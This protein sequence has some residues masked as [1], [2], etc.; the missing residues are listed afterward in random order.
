M[1]AEALII[2]RSG[3]LA[4]SLAQTL[5][6]GAAPWR[7]R[8]LDRSALDLTRPEQAG[9][10][11]TAA[12]PELV[13]IAA[14]YTAVDK[15]ESDEDTARL[16]NAASP[17]AIA[18]AC[19]RVG[20]ALVHVSTDYVFDGT[21]PAPYVETDPLAP[22]NA[23][24]RT[25]AEG[26]GAVLGAGARAA[27]IR[28]SWV[29]SPF[30][31]NFV[32]TMLRLSRERDELRVVDDQLGRPT[33]AADLAQ[34][35]LQVG[36]RLLDH[37]PVVSGLLHFSGSGDATWA[38]F[39][40]AVVAGGAARGGR[41]VPVRRVSSAEFPTPARRP[42]NSRLDTGKI[43]TLGIDSPPWRESLEHCLDALVASSGPL[44]KA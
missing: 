42:A 33:S 14:A 31:S 21:K 37:D 9:E 2:G 3:Q 25:K 28:T 4:Q 11:V 34:A 19:E 26:E 36:R 1:A 6:S 24:G 17:G 39:A 38:D 44:E 32:K 18:Q 22:A 7:A 13:V 16:V 23:Y 40:E 12:R 29:Y 43:N 30:G 5:D 27:V 8:F 35:V 10:I 41:S 15:A 20:A